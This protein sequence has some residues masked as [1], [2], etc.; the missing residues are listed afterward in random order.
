MTAKLASKSRRLINGSIVNIVTV[1]RILANVA[2][3]AS[4]SR[5]DWLR[6]PR[7]SRRSWRHHP[8]YALDRMDIEAAPMSFDFSS[9]RH[10]PKGWKI[11]RADNE[12]W[13]YQERTD[14]TY[15][16]TCVC[17]SEFELFKVSGLHPERDFV[18]RSDNFFRML[19]MT[20]CLMPQPSMTKQLKLAA[21]KEH[22]ILTGRI[23]SS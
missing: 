16:I 7:L 3:L 9:Y 13:L 5:H 6:N 12:L 1:V 2:S 18:A 23:Q 14:R 17:R 15:I 4:V 10:A 22:A 11:T 21:D 19:Q 8:S 20:G